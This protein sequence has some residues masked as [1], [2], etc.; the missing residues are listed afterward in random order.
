MRGGGVEEYRSAGGGVVLEAEDKIAG[1]WVM[2]RRTGAGRGVGVR[3][4]RPEERMRSDSRER[5][6]LR[7]AYL[8]RHRGRK[9]FD[10]GDVAVA[11]GA[12]FA[13]CD[14]FASYPITPASEI[15]E[16]LSRELPRAGGRQGRCRGRRRRLDGSFGLGGEGGPE[17]LGTDRQ[18]AFDDGPDGGRHLVGG[19]V[20]QEVAA[21]APAQG[22]QDVGRVVV[23]GD[24][25]D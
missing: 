24:D 11:W 8:R 22:L 1:G 6:E 20:L 14:F 19:G 13:G 17:E 23:E 21:G 12:L 3:G 25:D 2:K 18:P 9:L 10:L 16:F 5:A 4:R 7:A 15:G